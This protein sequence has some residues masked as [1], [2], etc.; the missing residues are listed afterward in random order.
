M[1]L[2]ERLQE[3]IASIDRALAGRSTFVSIGTEDAEFTAEMVG[4]GGKVERWL[5][6]FDRTKIVMQV[7]L[8]TPGGIT[9][10]ALSMHPASDADLADLGAERE[11]PRA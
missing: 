3:M 2:A 5:A 1:T 8:V 7:Q 10:Q 6:G 11:G 9:L 4:A